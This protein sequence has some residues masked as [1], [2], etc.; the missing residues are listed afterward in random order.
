MAVDPKPSLYGAVYIWKIEE[1]SSINAEFLLPS[2]L[3]GV[4]V[5]K[6]DASKSVKYIEIL[7][8]WGENIHLPAVFGVFPGYRVLDPWSLLYR[9]RHLRRLGM[10]DSN[11]NNDDNYQD[12]DER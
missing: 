6:W 2:W 8:I 4:W 9:G 7:C 5:L 3:E 12:D 10:I 1:I 11:D